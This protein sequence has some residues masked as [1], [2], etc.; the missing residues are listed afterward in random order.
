MPD[1]IDTQ[2]LAVTENYAAWLSHEP[3]GETIVH[4]ELGTV[5]VHLFREEWE[6]VVELVRLAAQELR[7]RT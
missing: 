2:E 7:K 3:D 1:D 6:E 4:L 5:T